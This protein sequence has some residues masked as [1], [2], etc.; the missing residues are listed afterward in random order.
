[1]LFA[2]VGYTT[3]GEDMSEKKK[4]DVLYITVSSH[5]H[6]RVYKKA[7]E[8]GLSKSQYVR[9]VLAKEMERD[10]KINLN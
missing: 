9:H 6:Q 3:T 2:S 7:Q 8:L 1:M 5:F 10:Q 4:K